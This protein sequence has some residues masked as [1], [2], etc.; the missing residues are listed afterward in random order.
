MKRAKKKPKHTTVVSLAEVIALARTRRVVY[1]EHGRIIG[2]ERID[3]ERPTADSTGGGLTAAPGCAD[4]TPE[5]LLKADTFLGRYR[6]R[7]LA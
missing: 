5:D 2:V 6:R 1:D 4:P 7:P 3:V